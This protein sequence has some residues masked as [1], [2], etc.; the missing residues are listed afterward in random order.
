MTWFCVYLIVITDIFS[1]CW[2]LGQEE[3]A[4]FMF[5]FVA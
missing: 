1:G 2:L 4:R 3:E 5:W